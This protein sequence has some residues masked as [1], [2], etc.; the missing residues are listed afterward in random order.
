MDDYL[1]KP[2][3]KDRFLAVVEQWVDRRPVIL[4]ADDAPESR[5]IVKRFLMI[6]GDY[7]LL[8]ATNGE[9]AV[10]LFDRQD[11]SL[12]LLDMEMPVL[13]GFETARAI[14][15]LE[16]GVEV[17]ILA[18][19]AHTDTG[20]LARCTEAGCTSVIQKPLERAKLNAV[21]VKHLK[22]RLSEDTAKAPRTT[23]IPESEEAPQ[24]VVFVDPDI[25]DLVPRFLENQKKNAALVLELCDAGDF[26][27]VRRIGHNMKGTGKG[28]G[29]EVISSCG[30]SLEQAA[31]KAKAPD[32][33]RVAK[34]LAAYLA[35]LRWEPRA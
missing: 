33:T 25:Q 21:V 28:Y 18:M 13:D 12:V 17:P 31:S 4:I 26:E 20:E 14:R 16:G 9:E 35:G 6:G 29:F 11:V 23:P 30:A 5:L 2:F 34:E 7:R 22:Q 8:F 24:G 19:T 10:E 32:V 1:T 3:K 15:S 27:T